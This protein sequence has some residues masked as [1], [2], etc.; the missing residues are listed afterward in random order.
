MNVK[1]L[2]LIWYIT[3]NATKN[4]C[5]QYQRIV[6]TAFIYKAFEEVAIWLDD[7]NLAKQIRFVDVDK[8]PFCAFNRLTY[9]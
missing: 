6:G 8:F 9:D 4:D 5:N 1:A 7:E 3:N 2:A